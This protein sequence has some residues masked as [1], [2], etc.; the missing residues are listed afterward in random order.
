MQFLGKSQ[1]FQKPMT[2]SSSISINDKNVTNIPTID[3]TAAM[4][5]H[6]SACRTRLSKCIKEYTGAEASKT[7]ATRM[8]ENTKSAIHLTC[9]GMRVAGTERSEFGAGVT[10]T[11]ALTNTNPAMIGMDITRAT[12]FHST[13][14]P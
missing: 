12:W 4:A 2:M 5:D 11:N 9:A 7:N 13:P 14:Q 8:E 6:N 10:N 1:N 3:A